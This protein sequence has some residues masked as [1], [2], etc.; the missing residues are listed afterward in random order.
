MSLVKWV[1]ISLVLL[2]AAE[3]AAFI[4]A[5]MTIGWLWTLALF[6]GTSVLGLFILRRTGR[7]DF[8]RF[9]VA[10]A[11][12]GFAAIH[13]ESPGLAAMIGGIL[14]VLPG[15]IT[16]LV[17]GMLLIPPLRR[18]ARAAIARAARNKPTAAARGRTM[19]DLEPGQWRQVP[20]PRTKKKRRIEDGR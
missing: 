3:I 4:L 18:Q 13:L 8:D 19:I 16:D 10:L 12:D 17:G 20:D 15:F 14:L 5:V 1:F 2:P 7:A 9:R 6:I 11:R